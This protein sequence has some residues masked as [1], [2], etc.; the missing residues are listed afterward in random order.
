LR[1]FRKDGTIICKSI[2]A[3]S[4]LKYLMMR[5]A[6]E[7]AVAKVIKKNPIKVNNSP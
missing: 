1:V 7:A 2:I 5:I 6:D 3:K 4:K